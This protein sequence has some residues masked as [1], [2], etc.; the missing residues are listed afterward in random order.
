MSKEV[1]IILTLII[2][3]IINI[4]SPIMVIKTYKDYT[5]TSEIVGKP[6]NSIQVNDYVHE[7]NY[8]FQE[9]LSKINFTQDEETQ[10]WT[11][12][13]YFSPVEF[14]GITNNYAIFIND[15]LLTLDNV[16][17]RAISGTH[18]RNFH[19][20]THD[21][22]NTTTIKVSFE[23]YGTYSYLLMT[24]DTDD[25][26]YFN[27]FKN[28]PGLILTLSKVD[29]YDMSNS[30]SKDSETF[31][32]R[33]FAEDHCISHEKLDKNSKLTNIPSLSNTEYGQFKG[34]STDGK[35]VIDLTDYTI[36]S[37][38]NFI[39][40][41]NTI[42]GN[43]FFSIKGTDVRN[44]FGDFS[45]VV[46]E[47]KQLVSFDYSIPLVHKE[48]VSLL[49]SDN[50][51]IFLKTGPTDMLAFTYDSNTDSVKAEL[52]SNLDYD[53]FI[54][55]DYEH[56]NYCNFVLK[57]VDATFP[58][59]PI[60]IDLNITEAQNNEL[61]T[62]LQQ[63]LTDAIQNK[64]TKPTAMT[65]ILTINFVMENDEVISLHILVLGKNSLNN[66]VA[67]NID[68]TNDISTL[69]EDYKN[70]NSTEYS[71]NLLVE[72]LKNII[73]NSDC[74]ATGMTYKQSENTDLEILYDATG[75][76]DLESNTMTYPNVFLIKDNKIYKSLKCYGPQLT[77]SE[78]MENI[79]AYLSGQPLPKE[80]LIITE[81]EVEVFSNINLIIK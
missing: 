38:V 76:Y 20:I 50:S 52:C 56:P 10:L 51:H 42:S 44:V 32:V 4:V 18:T 22:V 72:K 74:S 33:F 66:D 31:N 2:T 75:E 21:I 54:S 5:K 15:Y 39:A 26:T 79:E 16:S 36:T 7:S 69:Y 24:I 19:G 43:W 37:D 3:L 34:W 6:S 78:M 13:Y 61:L 45:L 9:N 58:T 1:R 41:W 65:C 29:F 64:I 57:R 30:M 23:F 70:F 55:G 67:Y 63:R 73:L 48:N 71:T 35:N 53:K 49:Y 62:S 11:Y 81:N 68:F 28:N 47:D 17:V 14:N 77:S 80:D 25:I 8:V 40:V 12:K 59:T 27:G 60:S 46:G